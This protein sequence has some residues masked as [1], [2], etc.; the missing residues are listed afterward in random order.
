MTPLDK[1][2]NKTS[3]VPFGY[4]SRARHVDPNARD[5]RQDKRATLVRTERAALQERSKLS[6]VTETPNAWL[7]DFSP[8]FEVL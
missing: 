8:G 6:G 5:S 3:D 4:P 7:K 1:G 2:I